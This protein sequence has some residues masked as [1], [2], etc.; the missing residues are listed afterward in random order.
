MTL[1]QTFKTWLQMF[2]EIAAVLRPIWLALLLVVAITI[3]LQVPQTVDALVDIAD[4]NFVSGSHFSLLIALAILSGCGWYFSRALLSVRYWFTPEERH[5]FEKWRR[6]VPRILGVLPIVAVAVTYVRSGRFGFFVF[7]VVMAGVFM[8]VVF[9]RRKR[10]VLG[11]SSQV[12]LYHEMPDGTFRVVASLLGLS[13]ILLCTFLV[14]PV[15]V[16]QKIG[17][18]AIAIYATASWIAVGCLLLVYPTYRYRLPSLVLLAFVCVGVFSVWNDNHSVRE[19]ADEAGSWERQP[20]KE[21]FSQW[22]ALRSG[23]WQDR[24]PNEPYPVFIIA[25]E[26]GGI[27]A[28][29]WTASVL[30]Y[31]EESNP[32]FGCHVY[33]ISGVSGGSLGGSVYA[34]LIADRLAESD[35]ACNAE[36]TGSSREFLPV[37]QSVLGEDFLAPALAGMLF[38]DFTQRFL[39]FS[40]AW[41]VVGS[42]TLP[43]RAKNLEMAWE[44]G[45]R[46]GTRTALG[47]ETNRFA[48][49]YRKL[50]EGEA[51]YW[52]PS[53]FL[54]GTWVESG[55]RNTTSNIRVDSTNFV[56][57]E[58]VVDYLNSPMPLSTAVHMSARF[59]YLSPAGTISGAT[60]GRRH[61]VDGGYFEN[62]GAL[63]AAEIASA[64]QNVDSGFVT[65]ALILTNSPAP[66]DKGPRFLSET[67]SPAVTLLNA[68]VAR[69]YRA[70]QFLEGTT[71]TVRFDLRNTMEAISGASVPLGWMLSESTRTLMNGVF[72]EPTRELKEAV[73]KVTACLQGRACS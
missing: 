42:L 21:H 8:L 68:R 28:A 27:R 55:G 45:W 26:G 47:N 48:E 43:D 38:S 57:L 20:I 72:E 50:W 25:A 46:S 19:G 34:A 71:P 4:Q 18:L 62:S 9:L 40:D 37:T 13:F 65:V 69:G 41:P 36:V 23:A 30:A 60:A 7:Y 64:I 32:G 35:Y 24:F 44:K 52:V 63:T 16:P 14:S 51:R 73:E 12:S 39:P 66:K 17:P 58:D 1:K 2:Q 3:A 31:V 29:Y 61:I 11:L 53:L 10:R 59:T 5:A 15:T 56:G 54:T 67:R 33:A 70:E 49:N 22:L 6:W